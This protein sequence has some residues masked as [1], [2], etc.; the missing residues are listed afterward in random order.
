LKYREIAVLLGV[1]IGTVMSRLY[2]A[3]KRLAEAM[4]SY[5]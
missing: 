1:P 3:R 2:A 4:E 5:R